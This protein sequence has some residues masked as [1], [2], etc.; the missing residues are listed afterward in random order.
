[1]SNNSK[2]DSILFVDDDEISLI[3]IVSRFREIFGD[4]FEYIKAENAED[5]LKYIKEDFQ[6]KNTLPRLVVIDWVMPGKLGNQL[7]EE[8]NKAY[9]DLP[10]IL[11]SGFVDPETAEIFKEKC[12]YITWLSK[13]W[14]GKKDLDIIEKAVMPK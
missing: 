6:Q 8:I 13:P 9:P 4:R 11:H 12:N 3:Q 1:M 5:A 10:V 7:I 14:N 2:K